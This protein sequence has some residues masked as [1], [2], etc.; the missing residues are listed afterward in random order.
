MSDRHTWHKA[1]LAPVRAALYDFDPG[2]LRAALHSVCA[3][4][5]QFHLALP[6][7]TILDVDAY[8]DKVYT[9]GGGGNPGP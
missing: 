1:L 5:A 9:P 4:D 6:F 7:E 8:V 3:P 2:T